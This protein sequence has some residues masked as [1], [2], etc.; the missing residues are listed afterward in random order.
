MLLVLESS[1]TISSSSSSRIIMIAAV[2]CHL[3]LNGALSYGV[4]DTS[5]R[6]QPDREA[7][8]SQSSGHWLI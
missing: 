3:W 8:V 6:F 4:L 5:N 1:H 2:I 7:L